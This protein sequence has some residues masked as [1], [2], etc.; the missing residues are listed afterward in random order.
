M[1]DLI[2]LDTLRELKGDV[3]G[4]LKDIFVL[5]ACWTKDLNGLA[6]GS[7]CRHALHSVIDATEFFLQEVK[8]AGGN[9]GLVVAHKIGCQ[10]GGIEGG[11]KSEAE[12]TGKSK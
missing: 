6:R 2:W 1:E 8:G 3:E 12:F 7:V 11:I 4:K 10:G 5:V 9:F